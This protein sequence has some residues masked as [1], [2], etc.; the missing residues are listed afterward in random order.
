M[1][2]INLRI[3]MVDHNGMCNEQGI[4]IGHSSK[5][6]HEYTQLIKEFGQI[7]AALPAC[8]E[9]NANRTDFGEMI[10]LPY[11]IILGNHNGIIKRILDKIKMFININKAVHQK[12]YDVIW[13]YKVDFFLTLYL[14][15]FD[16]G[17]KKKKY[18]GLICQQGFECPFKNIVNWIYRQGLKKFNG[19]IYT[20]KEDHI[21]HKNKMY[22]PD[23]YYIPEVY[24][25]YRMMKKQEKVVCVGTM[26]YYKEILELV[27]C[28]SKTDY[29]LDICGHF[30][31]QEMLHNVL[32][33]VGENI[34][35]QNKILSEDEYYT[36]IGSA[37][38]TILPY[39]MQQYK[40]RTSGVLY[41]TVF[42]NSIPIAPKALLAYNLISGVAYDSWEDLK[43]QITA[44]EVLPPNFSVENKMES[45]STIQKNLFEL[46][47]RTMNG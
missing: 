32:E 13:F 4:E 40:E 34:R 15:L 12:G 47:R 19:M 17:R 36:L 35:I 18:I 23:Y 38:Y 27:K 26:N 16:H 44:K 9:K 33:T 21:D 43:K 24:D 22:M 3:L 20:Q 5:V 7:D 6:L 46:M 42:L 31:D 29:T 14:W 8:I 45:I 25:K 11:N 37:K 41:E 30:M 10:Q 28:F 1:E 2:G 39:N